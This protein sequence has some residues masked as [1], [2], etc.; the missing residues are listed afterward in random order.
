MVYANNENAGIK[1][2]PSEMSKKGGDAGESD[3]D[4]LNIEDI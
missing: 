3:D 1:T 4:D 2:I